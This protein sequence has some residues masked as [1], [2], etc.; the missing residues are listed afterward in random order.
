MGVGQERAAAIA[1]GSRED[2]A[3]QAGLRDLE[4]VGRQLLHVTFGSVLT[5]GKTSRGRL[6]KD[7]I[8]EVLQ[9]HSALHEQVLEQHFT[10][11]FSLLNKG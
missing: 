4:V 2:D 6:F 8:V 11:H 9:N 7:A 5:T 10:K 1:V 3:T